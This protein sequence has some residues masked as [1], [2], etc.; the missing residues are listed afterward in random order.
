MRLAQALTNSETA[1]APPIPGILL[2]PTR[3]RRGKCAMLFRARRDDA[4]GGVDSHGARAAGANVDA[5]KVS[6]G[7][8][9]HAGAPKFWLGAGRRSV[10][11]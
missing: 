4:A 2:G 5:K 9:L 8:L 11:D 10:G 7:F 1:G 3:L 6:N